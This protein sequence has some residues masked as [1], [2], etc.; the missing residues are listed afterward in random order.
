M[1]I[2]DRETIW[3]DTI[4]M[5]MCHVIILLGIFPEEKQ[6]KTENN[7]MSPSYVW[8]LCGALLTWALELWRTHYCFVVLV[9]GGFMHLWCW[10]SIYQSL[11]TFFSPQFYYE[12]KTSV[13]PN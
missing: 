5:D 7:K 11:H 3:Y 10:W 6:N 1:R 12:L 13:K 8:A 4:E 2:G 9:R